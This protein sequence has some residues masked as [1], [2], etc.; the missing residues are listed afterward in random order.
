M[1]LGA[2]VLRIVICIFLP[3]LSKM[4]SR[5]RKGELLSEVMPQLRAA[6][7]NHGLESARFLLKYTLVLWSHISHV[8]GPILRGRSMSGNSTALRGTSSSFAE[9]T[10]QVVCVL[11][12]GD[13]AD[14]DVSRQAAAK[15]P[16]PLTA[17]LSAGAP[18]MLSWYAG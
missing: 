13:E 11:P 3:F 6:S 1:H 9:F 17:T 14:V 12:N 18:V 7:W 10:R 15:F 16:M 4:C 8:L 2:L 5:L